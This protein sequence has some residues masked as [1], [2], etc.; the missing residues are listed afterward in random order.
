M[1]L[2]RSFVT[3]ALAAFARP[4][5]RVTAVDLFPVRATERTVWLLVRVKTDA[6]ITGWGEAS[7][8]FGFTSTTKD[9][10]AKLAALLKSLSPLITGK[11]PLDIE[12]FRQAAF[13]QATS[14]VTATAIS[15]IEQALWDITG[16]LL[17]LPVHALFG[18]KTRSKL[19]VYANIN[20]ATKPRT[21]DGFA[22]SAKAAARDGFR[23]LK[24]APWDGFPKPGSPQKEIDAYVDQG[25]ACL[26]AVRQAV[27]PDIAVMTDCH[28]FFSVPLA[29]NVAKRLEPVNLGWYEEP[30]PP[31][32][33]R[34]T[35]EIRQG[36]KQQMAGG[37][38]LFRVKGFEPL[39]R[40]HAVHVIMPDVKHCGGLLEMTHIAAMAEAHGVTVAPHNPSG[41]IATAA[42]IHV[43]A[44]MK[45]FHILEM[46]WGEVDWRGRLLKPEE[47][48]VNGE[49]AVSD[50]PGLGVTVDETLA[51]KFLA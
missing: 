49:I 46:Q 13:P 50:A 8:A 27:G 4:K 38:I 37:E 31:E 25:I 22:A 43:C 21:P 26:F 44:G 23:H 5:A 35:V 9:D 28:S 19:P 7:D 51:A 48:F 2:R 6:G 41:P 17:D 42:S 16:Q 47:K 39:C 20:R 32:Q 3:T 14:L 30:V 1:M 24:L 45:N 33:T 29:I 36:I 11:S 10:Q 34:E 18:G 15:A 40:Q 12:P